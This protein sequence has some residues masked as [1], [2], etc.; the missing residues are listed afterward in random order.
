MNRAIE[1]ERRWTADAAHELRTP[2]T[3]I[4]THVQ[5]AQLVLERHA[6]GQAA[7]ATPPAR[8]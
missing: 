8:L 4:K 6:P 7:R 2:L 5:V 1:H 3:A